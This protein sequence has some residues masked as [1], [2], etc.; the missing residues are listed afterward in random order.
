MEFPG[1]VDTWIGQNWSPQEVSMA[2]REYT[3]EFKAEAVK[4]PAGV[5]V[6]PLAGRHAGIVVPLLYHPEIDV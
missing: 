6:G 1:F 3:E 5:K 2:N 4:Q